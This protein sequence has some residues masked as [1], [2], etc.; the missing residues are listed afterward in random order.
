MFLVGLAFSF[1]AGAA[2][3]AGCEKAGD[4]PCGGPVTLFLEGFPD[5]LKIL[6]AIAGIT[7]VLV[8]PFVLFLLSRFRKDFSFLYYIVLFIDFLLIIISLFDYFSPIKT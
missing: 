5:E 4:Y 3:Y 7:I 8:V 1:V 2:S 6:W